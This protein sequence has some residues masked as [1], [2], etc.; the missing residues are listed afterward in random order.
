MCGF[1][2]GTDPDWDYEAALT[3]IAHRGPDAQ[4]LHRSSP[5]H[6]GFCRLAIIDLRDVANQPMFADDGE[7]WIT[8]NGEIYGY[9]AIRADLERAGQ[10]FKTD[11]D[12]EVVL[13]AYLTWGE[14]FI[15]R[16][17]GMFAIAIWDARERKLKLFR[18]RPGIKPLYYYYDGRRFAFASELKALRVACRG[19]G[20][21]TDET[22]L[23]DFLTYRY[24]PAPKT[25]YKN[26]FKLLPAHHLSFDPDSGLLEKPVSYWRIVIPEEP[27]PRSLDECAEE[28]RS[29]VADSIRDQMIADVP[30]GFFLSGGVDSSTVVA[31]A[32]ASSADLSTFSIGFDTA[33]HS[34]VSYA[35]EV[36]E[37]F[38][39]DHHERTLTKRHAQAL[40]PNVQQWFDEPFADE[41]CLPTQF[42]SATAREHVTVVLTGD[43]GDEVFGGY[44]TYT[45]FARYS[46]YPSWPRI[47]DTWVSELRKRVRGGR[48]KK[49]LAQ[50]EWAFSQDISLWDK[51]MGGLTPVEKLAYAPELGIGADYDHCWQY[52]RHWR[53]DVPLMT[54]LQLVDFHTYLP[55]DI[56]TKVDR[57]SMSVSLEARVPLLARRVIEFGFSLPENIRY[58]GGQLKGLLKY[59]YRGIL[60][61]SVLDRRKKGFSTPRYYFGAAGPAELQKSIFEEYR[62]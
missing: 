6:V 49:A 17:D 10:R 40:L 48:M 58:A 26:C 33:E 14:S 46:R 55:D 1:V 11:A 36:A 31:S 21:S 3:A 52:R 25:L 62:S 7:T 51:L 54:R 29:I 34:E 28:L 16:I 2:G 8:F 56:L 57:T 13:R 39:T 50:I 38:G 9:K 53:D 60:P 41:S 22:A 45:R 47:M 18:D 19:D 20:L 15:D 5:V 24:I 42:V 44:R 30:L 59:A 61:D 27:E 35:R 32:S 4:Q 23:Y 12:T 37:K 43:G